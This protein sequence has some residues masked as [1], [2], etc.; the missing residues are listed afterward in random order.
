MVRAT[1]RMRAMARAARL[2]NADKEESQEIC[3]VPDGDYARLVEQQV[4]Y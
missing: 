2:P 4:I 1:R 3:F